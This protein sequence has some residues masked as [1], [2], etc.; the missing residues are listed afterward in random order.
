M[1]TWFWEDCSW[2]S[3]FDS[4]AICLENS[5]TESSRISALR[6]I[7]CYL[8][9]PMCH[10]W[11]HKTQKGPHSYTS[12][13]RK[14]EH[15]LGSLSNLI[16][17]GRRQINICKVHISHY[18]FASCGLDVS[19]PQR[20]CMNWQGFQGKWSHCPMEWGKTGALWDNWQK[21]QRRGRRERKWIVC[22]DNI[23]E[24]IRRPKLGGQRT[25]SQFPVCLSSALN[26]P[27]WLQ[28]PL[29]NEEGGA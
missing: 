6:D 24:V 20:G 19:P 2:G 3:I 25:C 17:V 4:S 9:G 7:G 1:H 12:D 28:S 11:V 23:L 10:T 13:N 21:E 5:F 8:S 26:L 22:C 27:P 15:P 14:E 16:T 29:L 18:L